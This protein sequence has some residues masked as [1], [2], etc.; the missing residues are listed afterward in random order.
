MNV[1]IYKFVSLNYPNTYVYTMDNDSGETSVYDAKTL[2]KISVID[3][4]AEFIPVGSIPIEAGPNG[5][6]YPKVYP[7]PL[8]VWESDIS[9]KLAFWVDNKFVD[10]MTYTPK[11]YN[12]EV[13][14]GKATKLLV[15]TTFFPTGN[16]LPYIEYPG[17]LYVSPVEELPI[18]DKQICIDSNVFLQIIEA[19]MRRTYGL[20]PVSIPTELP[21]NGQM[22]SIISYEELLT[23]SKD[24]SVIETSLQPEYQPF[25][26]SHRNNNRLAT[27]KLINGDIYLV[28]CSYDEKLTP[29]Y[30]PPK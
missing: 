7:G 9:D 14:T 1:I 11:L 22:V 3:D 26:G 2:A 21:L 12:G 30:S 29:K 15:P 23:K 13:Y 6:F 20:Y 19:H 28:R 24:N 10:P 18:L 4:S 27:F 8:Y 5:R 16:M 25:A 17:T